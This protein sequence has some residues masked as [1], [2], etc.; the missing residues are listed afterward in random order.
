[1]A[2]SGFVTRIFVTRIPVWVRVPV[3]IAL[4]LVGIFAGSMLLGAAD[5][6]RDPGEGHGSG[7]D[8]EMSDHTGSGAGSSGGHEPGDDMGMTDHSGRGNGASGEGHDRGD[9]A[10]SDG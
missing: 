5:V 3:I 9:Q 4:V 10:G 7:G 8:T 1:M 6:G 2:K